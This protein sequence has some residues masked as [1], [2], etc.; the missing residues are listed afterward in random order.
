LEETKSKT[1]LRWEMFRVEMC[2][3]SIREEMRDS[4]VTE[5]LLRFFKGYFYS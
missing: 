5:Y 2:T 4:N 1:T 3:D